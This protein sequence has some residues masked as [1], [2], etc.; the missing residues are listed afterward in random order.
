MQRPPR[1]DFSL[2]ALIDW[3][4][5]Q[6]IFTERS[7][8]LARWSR[9][10]EMA[11]IERQLA[12]EVASGFQYLRR[13]APVL[14]RYR[15]MAERASVTV[16][17]VLD[18]RTDLSG[19]QLMALAPADALVKEWFLIVQHPGYTRAL[20]ARELDEDAR[21]FHGILTSDPAQ[22]ERFYHALMAYASQG[23]L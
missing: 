4:N 16:F 14:P 5:V 3:T 12:A 17:G 2:Y 18:S 1:A 9:D 13:I 20:V 23:G 19:L 21:T 11:V 6:T 10:I 7:D 8:L 22:V 15:Q